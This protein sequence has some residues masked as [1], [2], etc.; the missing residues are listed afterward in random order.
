MIV[1]ARAAAIC[2]AKTPPLAVPSVVLR[3]A[4]AL[5]D[6][7]HD[8]DIVVWSETQAALLR[9]AARGERVNDIDWEHVAEEIEDVGNSE[10]RT[11]ESLWLQAMLHLIKLSMLPEDQAALHWRTEITA[12]LTQADNRYVPSMAQRIDLD[13][14]WRRCRTAS[15]QHFG[16]QTA[17]GYLPD[18]CPW[19]VAQLLDGD[20]AE[21]WGA[22]AP[23][24]Q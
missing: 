11:V 6:A 23:R 5:S 17:F 24:P 13:R 15:A 1:R 12:F 4:S 14:L 16:D 18:R 8:T 20:I 10:L 3:E 2:I 21:L 19:S 22:L 7:L 9:R